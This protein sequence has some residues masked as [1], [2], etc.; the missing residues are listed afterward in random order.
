MSIQRH[1]LPYHSAIMLGCDPEIFL[2]REV[3]KLKK[4]TR[5]V[6]SEAVIPV[7]GLL[8]P[9]SFSKLTRDG[10]QVELH[11]YQATCRANMSNDLSGLFQA[12]KTTLAK[13][14]GIKVDF[15]QVVRLTKGDL[16][17][18]SPEGRQ[19]GCMPSLNA[20]GRKFIQKNGE[21]YRYRSASGH[22]HIGCTTFSAAKDEDMVRYVHIYDTLVGNTCVLLDRDPN[23]A[24][25]RKL[26][27]RAGEYRRPA[28]GLEY[29]TLSNFWL[30]GYPLFS[31]VMGLAYQAARVAQSKSSISAV[32]NHKPCGVWDVRLPPWDAETALMKDVDLTAIE[33]AINT[34]DFDLALSNYQK[35]VRPFFDQVQSIKGLQSSN[36]NNF[37]KFVAGVQ[38]NGLKH[39]FPQDPLDH[40]TTKGDGHGKGWET[41]I[42]EFALKFKE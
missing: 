27:G 34:N 36:L 42:D 14:Q 25:R 15:S 40:W 31:M 1:E 41:F 8:G 39:Y 37:D 11:P 9:S 22:V 6:G 5:I 30:L 19:L 24:L 29:R 16:M 3:G 38:K 26:Y 20:Y 21:K 17:R 23:A 2:A 13:H 35:W 33:T 12:L 7:N 4:R 18:I 28:H 32:A 10:V